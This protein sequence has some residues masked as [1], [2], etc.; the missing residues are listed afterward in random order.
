MKDKKIN[1]LLVDNQQIFRE[2]VKR[3]LEQEESFHVIVSSD[4]Y[5]VVKTLLPIQSVDV[6]LIDVM[7]ALENKEAIR[8]D[9]IQSTDTK[10]I[11]MSVERE[12][13]YVTQAVK[14]GIHGYL[15]KEM[16]AFSFIDAIKMVVNGASYIHPT[17]THDLV[18]EYRMLTNMN[19]ED[20][21]NGVNKPLHLYTK[22]ECEVLQLLTDG[23]SNRQ[24]AKR[25]KI[26]EKT[27]KNHVSSLFKKM[28]VND[29]TQA[30]VTAIRNN[31]VEL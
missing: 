30:V 26:S 23:N 16:E 2:G 25:L 17:V 31:W 29:R 28:N 27:V 10:V 4:D 3:V 1:I 12:E 18:K 5:S 6:I 7:I 15:L 13:N 11:I 19:H 24:I 22:R 8:K 20:T 14:L 9:I 21:N